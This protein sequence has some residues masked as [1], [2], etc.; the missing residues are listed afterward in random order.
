M[1][2]TVKANEIVKLRT[3]VKNSNKHEVY[4]G[5]KY[6]RSMDPRAPGKQIKHGI[7]R[8][9]RNARTVYNIANICLFV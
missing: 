6:I 5:F 9:D 8:A 7:S 4:L 1:K 2:A 3:Y